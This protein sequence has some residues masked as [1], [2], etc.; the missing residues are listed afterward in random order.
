VNHD[1][2]EKIDSKAMS[3]KVRARP[4]T[5]HW[6]AHGTAG[7]KKA[8]RTATQDETEVAGYYNVSN[9]VDKPPVTE[10]KPG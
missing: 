1:F 10:S 7:G 3:V 4:K 8:S 9:N 2:G 6:I 5:A